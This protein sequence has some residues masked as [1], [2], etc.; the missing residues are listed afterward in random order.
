[1]R[2]EPV[3]ADRRY[4]TLPWLAAGIGLILSLV[5]LYAGEADRGEP[6]LPPLMLLF[7][8]ELGF[9]LSLI[10]AWS[11]M[12]LWLAEQRPWPLLLVSAAC[13]IMTLAFL[14]LGFAFWGGLVPVE[15]G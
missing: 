14:Y 7:I 3:G 4:K 8:S 15:A 6:P 1:V 13:A 10:G 11:G 12:R 9:L 2:S 5:L